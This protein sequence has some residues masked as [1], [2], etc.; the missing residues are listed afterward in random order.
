VTVPLKPLAAETVIVELTV[1]PAFVVGGEED[2]S[3]KSVGGGTVKEK[4]DENGPI[5]PALSTANTLQ[6][7]VPAG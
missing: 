6:Y 2:A 3:E 7:Q 5:F 4:V 1:D